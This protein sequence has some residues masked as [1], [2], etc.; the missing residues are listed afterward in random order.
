MKNFLLIFF[1]VVLMGCSQE[2]Y[3]E[4]IN[5]FELHSSNDTSITFVANFNVFNPNNFDITLNRF[6]YSVFY[7]SALIATGFSDENSLLQKNSSNSLNTI[8]NINFQNLLPHIQTISSSDSTVLVIELEAVVTKFRKNVKRKFTIVL[9]SSEIL[10]NF[11]SDDYFSETYKIQSASLKN[12]TM[13]TSTFEV[14][15]AFTNNL[16]INYFV[17]NINFD[18]FDDQ[19]K[20]NKVGTSSKEYD[21][22]IQKDSTLIIPIE[23]TLNNVNMAFS[24]FGKLMSGNFSYYIDGNVG[25]LIS[26]NE[27]QLPLKQTV[28]NNN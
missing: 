20:A 23:V 21:I 14:L 3:F 18:I 24:M 12:V 25:L 9:N 27:L 7:D 8:I 13:Q 5:S 26:G 4:K 15:I 11:L 22:Q 17:K 1:S 28:S 16:P 19:S 6:E 2:P 10:T